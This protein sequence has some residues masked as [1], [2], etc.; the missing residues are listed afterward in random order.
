MQGKAGR[1]EVMIRYGTVRGNEGKVMLE[2]FRAREV[3]C[4]W[5]LSLRSGCLR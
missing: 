1:Y 4:G 2:L 3:W 5:V